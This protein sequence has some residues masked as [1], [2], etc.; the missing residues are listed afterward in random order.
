MVLGANVHSEMLRNWSK[1][2]PEG[3]GPVSHQEE[4]G[5]DQ[6][7]L[8]DVFRRLEGKF[9]RQLKL[10][11]SSCDRQDEK[12]DELMEKTRE[13]RQRS[14]SLEHDDA[15]QPRLAME[16]DSKTIQEDSQAHGGRRWSRTS[17]EWDNS[18]AQVDTDPIHLTSFGNDS[19]RPPALSCSRNDALV[20]NGPAPTKPCLSL[21]EMRTGTAAE[22]LLSAGTA[23]T[24]IRT[25]FSRPLPSWTLGEET[26]E[27][28]SRT[29]NN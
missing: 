16:A 1:S 24:A 7:T 27:R 29:N 3:N 4:I 26:N 22:G 25:I 23:S 20:D 15:R 19:A 2:I 21:L 6:S 17:D 28:T 13:P 10:I 5:P 14:A 8:A 12:L 11:K 18:S 9:D